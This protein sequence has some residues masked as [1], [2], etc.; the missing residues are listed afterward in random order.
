MNIY[1]SI[2]KFSDNACRYVHKEARKYHKFGIAFLKAGK[3]SF[4][5]SIAVRIILGG[6]AYSL[7]T[8]VTRTLKGE[9]SGIV[10]DNPYYLC[11]FNGSCVDCIKNRLKIGAAAGYTYTNSHV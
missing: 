4:I 6:N 2:L 11:V 10:A 8:A 5:K 9:G 1:Y 3:K 7:N